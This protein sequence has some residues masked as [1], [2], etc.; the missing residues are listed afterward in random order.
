MIIPLFVGMLSGMFTFGFFADWI[1]KKSPRF[2]RIGTIQALQVAYAITAFFGT[3]FVYG[4][5]VMYIV[6]FFTMGFFGSAN[7]GVN[8]PIIASVVPPELR[9]TAFALFVSVFEAIAWGFYNIMAGQL[10]ERFGLKPVFFGILVVLM[11][12]NAAFITFLY[13]PYVHD[14]Q[15]L[16]LELKQRREQLLS[17]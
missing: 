1:H 5:P 14:V 8:R 10:G 4:N 3:Q 13:K 7:M 9:G 15:A 16:H 17:E 12:I 2:G 6:L 11:L